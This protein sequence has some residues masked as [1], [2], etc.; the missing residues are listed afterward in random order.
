[1]RKLVY[2]IE[3]ALD[4]LRVILAKI[5]TYRKADIADSLRRIAAF[6]YAEIRLVFSLGSL[7]ADAPLFLPLQARY[8]RLA[9]CTRRRFFR[10]YRQ[11]RT[12]YLPHTIER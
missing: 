11:E 7:V 9:A 4:R 10:V 5:N 1:M 6:G 8:G 12:A 2:G 3:A